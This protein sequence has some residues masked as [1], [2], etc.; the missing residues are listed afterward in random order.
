MHR[1]I[2][3]TSSIVRETTSFAAQNIYNESIGEYYYPIPKEWDEH[4]SFIEVKERKTEQYF[5]VEKAD[6]NSLKWVASSK[7]SDQFENTFVMHISNETNEI[8]CGKPKN[9]KWPLLHTSS[10]NNCSQIQYYKISFN[11][12]LDPEDKIKF[13]VTTAFTHMLT[14][15]PKEIAQT[16]RQNMLFRGNQYGN[17]AY[18]TAQQKTVVKLPSVVIISYSQPTGFITNNRNMLEYGLFDGKEPNSYEE[19][20]IHYELQQSIL[21]VKGLRR[22]LEISH[23]GGN[24]AIE[25]HF[26]LTQEGAR[27]KDNFSRLEYHKNVY[28]RQSSIMTRELSLSLPVHASNVYYRDEIGNV[29]T[30]HLRYEQDKAVLEFKPRYPLFGGWNYTWYYGYNVPAGDFV[31]YHSESGRYILN[32]PF[33]NVL[34][35]VTYDKV[36]VRIILPEGASNVK[37]ETPFPV[38]KESHAVHKTYLDTIGR[39][40]IVLDKFNVLNDHAKNIQVSY[41]YSSFELLRKP[42]AVSTCILGAFLL[43]MIYSRM[44]FGI[45]KSEK[46]S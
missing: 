26:N 38:D 3:L 1:T 8:I 29:S 39:Y 25:E 43:S 28:A 14:P 6:F 17:S 19:L 22:D 33:I 46:K 20:K 11:R 24:L 15:Y 2:D 40:L 34:P 27:L 35:R 42:L 23:W 31:R 21:T 44:E 4:L 16:G 37:V 18:Y 41:T 13:T 9:F 30:S 12:R 10:M 32:I 5:E 45:G 7:L 36:Q